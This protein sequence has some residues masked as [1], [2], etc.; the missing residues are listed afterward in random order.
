MTKKHES[1]WNLEQLTDEEIYAAIG[2][3][4]PDPG[5]ANKPLPQL[6]DGEISAVIRYL[7]PDSEGA[8]EK[9]HF[10]PI[11]ICVGL[12]LLVIVCLEFVWF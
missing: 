11:V 9:H 12:V 10:T 6:T 4:D 5:S 8:N 1:D 2:D 7:D 3:L